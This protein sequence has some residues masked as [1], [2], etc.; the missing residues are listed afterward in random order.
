MESI[1]VF[2]SLHSNMTACG[3][4]MKTE[5]SMLLFPLCSLKTLFKLVTLTMRIVFLFVLDCRCNNDATAMITNILYCVLSVIQGIA[6]NTG[7]LP[8]SKGRVLQEHRNLISKHAYKLDSPFATSPIYISD[9]DY[10][11]SLDL[12]YISI[13]EKEPFHGLE[14]R[15]ALEHMNELSSLSSLFSDDK[16]KRMYFVTKIFP[17]S[18][19]GEAKSWYDSL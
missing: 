5:G 12:S 14:T 8:F 16:K 1:D 3:V 9:K 18:L 2:S 7:I 4:M 6:L 13:V 19:K 17:F 11:F 10:D 15:N